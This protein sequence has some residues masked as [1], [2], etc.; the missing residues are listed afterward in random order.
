[1][2]TESI[3]EFL[4]RGGKIK[5]IAVGERPAQINADVT[6]KAQESFFEKDCDLIEES[7]TENGLLEITSTDKVIH[8][9]ELKTRKPTWKKIWKTDSNF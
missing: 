2:K 4:K 1:M 6:E 3:A 8:R 9:N 7:N 5:K